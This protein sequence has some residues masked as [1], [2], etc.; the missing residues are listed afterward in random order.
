MPDSTMYDTAKLVGVKF[1]QKYLLLALVCL[2]ATTCL[3]T[4]PAWAQNSPATMIAPP[5]NSTGVD[6]FVAFTWNGVPNGQAYYLYVGTNVGLKNVYDSG[7]LLVTSIAVPGLQPN[8]K[9][10]IRLW[11]EFGGVWQDYVDS[12]FTTGTG[13]AHLT[14]P[15]DSATGVDPL[16]AFTWTSVLDAEVYYLYVGTGIGLKDV[17]DSKEL[18]NSTS[19][20]VLGLVPNHLYYARMW[21]R[22]YTVWY[23]VDS[24]FT[25]GDGI[26]RLTNP[27]NGTGAVPSSPTF[28]WNNI[29]DAQAYR[30]YIGSSI[31]GSDVYNSGTVTG[32]QIIVSGLSTSNKTYYA[33]LWTEKN[34]TWSLYSDS[35]FTTGTVSQIVYPPNGTQNANS[36][37][38]FSWSKIPNATM[39]YITVGTTAGADDVFNGQN[40]PGTS[41][42][43][44]GLLGGKTYYVTVHTDING[45]WSLS[46]AA[47]FKTA[48]QPS[49][50]SAA[51]FHTN[52]A[53]AT[54]VVRDMAESVDNTPLPDTFLANNLFSGHTIALCSDF[55]VNLVL[56]LLNQGIPAR[57]RDTIFTGP[58]SHTIAE[59]YDPYL[60]KWVVADA[61]FGLI[62]YDPTKSPTSVGVEDVNVALLNR[63]T[64]SLPLTYVTS[65]PIPGDTSC[66]SGVKCY[67]SYWTSNVYQDMILYYLNPLGVGKPDWTQATLPNS[68]LPFLASA[69]NKVGVSGTYTFLF[70]NYS[71][72]VNV[73]NSRNGQTKVQPGVQPNPTFLYSFDWRFN[74]Q[75]TMQ[76]PSGQTAPQIYSIPCVLF[77]ASGC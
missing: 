46:N 56:Q 15:T 21:T 28:V 29:S 22:K 11:T 67:G 19:L 76:V 27:A 53:L 75:W 71:D 64:A 73:T 24:T 31:G 77:Q 51:S 16:A 3:F 40:T 42:F 38:P 48:A 52:V 23:Y 9:Y 8:T 36:F 4:R 49:P 7:A 35:V 6:P 57:R 63:T 50:H 54:A 18:P 39:Y 13:L 37:V 74:P 1:L 69:N 70:S 20:T 58:E 47:S 2:L 60:A 41:Q 62:F 34:S 5:D 65:S 14:F 32:T 26:A 12:T 55:T 59:Y 72:Y 43:V 68:P 30:L 44:G 45:T 25:T 61:D 66:P 17:Y 33:R 10:Y